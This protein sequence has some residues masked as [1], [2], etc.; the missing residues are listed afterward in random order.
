MFWQSKTKVAEVFHTFGEEEI[1]ELLPKINT[2]QE[3]QVIK[4]LVHVKAMI[5]PFTLLLFRLVP[6][7]LLRRLGNIKE[8][9]RASFV[10]RGNT[11][12][13]RNDFTAQIKRKS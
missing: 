10:L 4:A 2:Q 7:I 5:M 13:S 11:F 3:K 12:S 9:Y 8:R 1:A 6:P